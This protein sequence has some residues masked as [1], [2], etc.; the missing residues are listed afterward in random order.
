MGTI[1]FRASAGS[2]RISQKN[3]EFLADTWLASTC[4]VAHDLVTPPPS[5]PPGASLGISQGDHHTATAQTK[6]P[7]W[8]CPRYPHSGFGRV[9]ASL[10]VRRTTGP[11]SRS[12][13]ALFGRADP[14][15]WIEWLPKCT[16]GRDRCQSRSRSGQ[17]RREG[18]R[19]VGVVRARNLRPWPIECGT[20]SCPPGLGPESRMVR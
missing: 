2:M 3:F 8:G 18:G 16:P 19:A 14:S 15:S 11:W 7:F 10:A 9:R 6:R 13:A 17:S 1:G 4:A 20:G 12:S 5:E